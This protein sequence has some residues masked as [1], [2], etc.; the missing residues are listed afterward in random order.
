MNY[1]YVIDAYG[2]M[3]IGDSFFLSHNSFELRVGVGYIREMIEN[4]EY[5]ELTPE[6]LSAKINARSAADV[7]AFK[8]RRKPYLL[9]S[10]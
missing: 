3:N 10:E 9:Y 2:K 7:E 8:A 1:E 6:E 5:S 4:N